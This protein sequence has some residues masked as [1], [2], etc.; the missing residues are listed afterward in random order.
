MD[1]YLS[2]E[3][4][5]ETRRDV[6]AH[7]ERCEDC[8]RAFD[9]YTRIKVRLKRAFLNERAPATLEERI[10]A[11]IR[12]GR[13]PGLALNT[14]WMLAAAATIAMAAALGVLLQSSTNPDKAD[15]QSLSLVAEVAP[16]DASGQ[17]LR[18]GFDQ[19]VFCALD[20]DM[21]N[22]RFAAEQMSETLGS[23][24]E[25]LVALAEEKTPQDYEVVVGHRCRY[26]ERE[27]VHLILRRQDEV[28]SLIV[29]HKKDEAFQAGSGRV[30]VFQSSWHNLH[31]AG[32]QTRDHLVFVV[33]DEKSRT[34][35]EISATLVAAVGDFVERREG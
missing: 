2:N 13:R 8:A 4:P 17:I 23:Q 35:D 25:G 20:H 15:P 22:R 21:A 9:D 26:R 34:S 6:L 32:T 19:H 14:S 33:S 11:S 7:L 30:P 5:V 24:Y 18:V 27:F 16:G 3:L 31:V 1:S 29:T 10:R 12:R 28:V